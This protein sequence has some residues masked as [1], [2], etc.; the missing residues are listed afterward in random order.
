MQF[1]ANRRE[2]NARAYASIVPELSASG[3]RVIL[4]SLVHTGLSLGGLYASGVLPMR[5]M[6]WR[7]WRRPWLD[8]CQFCLLFACR[9]VGRLS[10]NI[11]SY[12]YQDSAARASWRSV[13]FVD[14][15]GAIPA[16]SRAKTCVPLPAELRAVGR[17]SR[18]QVCRVR[19][20]QKIARPQPPPRPP[21]G[22]AAGSPN[23]SCVRQ[24]QVSRRCCGDC[25][26]RRGACC[27]WPYRYSTLASCHRVSASLSDRW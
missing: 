13:L 19:A 26:S 17:P 23:H 25:E 9:M 27:A 22:A 11:I 14:G 18:H 15:P 10:G 20:L 21:R 8:G 4:C 7:D 1:F 16:F 24:R 12:T 6:Q 2:T 5:R 3:F